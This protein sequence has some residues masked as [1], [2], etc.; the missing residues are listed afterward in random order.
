MYYMFCADGV[1]EVE[2]LAT[3][4]ILR[5]SYV[6]CRTVALDDRTVRGA[7]GINFIADMEQY[8]FGIESGDLEGIIIPGG[9]AVEESLSDNLFLLDLIKKVDKK[10]LMIAAICAAPSLPGRL[11]LMTGIKYACFPGFEHYMKGGI[12][13]D[14]PVVRDGRFITARSMAYSVDFA[15]EIVKYVKGE[16]KAEEVRKSVYCR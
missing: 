15:L 12:N 1:E 16:E 6:P 4:D 10:G 11:G 14:E 3:L 9:P 7:H 8:E 2:A 13:S 5:R